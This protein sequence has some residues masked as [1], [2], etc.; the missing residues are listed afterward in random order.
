M[1]IL[2]Y[3]VR[4][5]LD[6][7]LLRLV[8][9]GSCLLCGA[10]SNSDLLCAACQDDL[11]GMPTFRCPQCAMPTTHGERCGACLVQMPH[12]SACHALYPYEFPADRLVQLL[13]YGHQLALAPWF[14]KQLAPLLLSRQADLIIPLPL[15]PHR[16]RERGFNQA[17]EISRALGNCLKL[18]VDRSSLARSRAT[19]PQAALAHKDRQANVKG[20]F[21]C[22][23]DLSGKSILLIDDVLT[24]GATANEC[25]RVLKLHGA[26]RVEVAVVARAYRH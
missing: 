16:L 17:G 10:D 5:S 8:P 22:R 25:A 13:K 7:R 9:C 4:Q 14:A 23:S 3:P 19:P 1:S 24:T 12:F 20:A 11:P 26:Q 21:E 2:P 6:Q 15:H 18:P